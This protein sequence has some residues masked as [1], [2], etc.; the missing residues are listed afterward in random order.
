M[1]DI[2]K[3]TAAYMPSPATLAFA[4]FPCQD[5]SIAGAGRGL[6]GA[7]SRTFTAFW[8]L[9]DRL[10]GTGRQVPII[11]LENVT[12]ALTFNGGR[13]FASILTAICRCGY[14]VGALVLDAV[15]FLP[16]YRPRLIIVAVAGD[17][18]LPLGAPAP[19]WHDARLLP[20]HAALP[21]SLK[22]Q[23][24]W[25]SLPAPP[26]S[27]TLTALIEDDPAGVEWHTPAQTTLLSQMS[28]TNRAKVRA[29]QSRGEK[30]AGTVYKRI[31]T[32]QG[33]KVQRAEVRF[34]QI[35]GRLRTPAGGFSRQTLLLVE[36]ASLRS[37]LLSA[38]EAARLMG[39]PAS[40]RLPANYNEAYRLIGDGL[41][42]PIVEWLEQHLLRPLA[43]NVSSAGSKA[44]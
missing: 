2:R 13:D 10:A 22:R 18:A 39:L 3:M 38:R 19:P 15:H 20:A 34:D 21:Q 40:Y 6:E 32:E 9:V 41:V 1:T 12:G 28:A 33:A 43:A 5:L 37:R 26:M 36:G 14:R 11:V 27:A 23:W 16:R 7:R 30:I 17:C 24:L 25:W 35:G 8:A 4:S 31:R 29:A 42:I 44:A